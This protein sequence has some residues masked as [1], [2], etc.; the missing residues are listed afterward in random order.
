MWACHMDLHHRNLHNTV[1]EESANMGPR[2]GDTYDYKR[3]PEDEENNIL[4]FGYSIEQGS[5]DLELETAKMVD[6]LQRKE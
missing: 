1:G 6:L 5:R 2:D 3:N 4:H